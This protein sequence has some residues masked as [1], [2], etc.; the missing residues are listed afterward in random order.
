M[1]RPVHR[2]KKAKRSRSAVILSPNEY[3][4]GVDGGGT[5]THALLMDR[6]QQVIGEGTAGPS[7][8]L[9]VGVETAVSNILK[10]VNQACDNAVISRADIVS[11]T[12][13]L[14]G[15]RRSDMK[16]RVRASFQEQSRIKHIN[17][18]TDAE[19]AL[20]ATTL[21][22]PGVVVIAGTGSVCLGMS[23]EDKYAMSGGWGP[24]AGD[25]GGGA[26]IARE[27]LQAVAKASDGRGIPT[28][29]S[30]RAS[31][32]FRASGPENLIV[33]IYSPHVDNSRIAGFAEFVVEA[34]KRGDSVAIDIIAAA[35]AELG[36]AA[37]AVIEKLGLKRKKVPIGCVGSVFKA[38]ELLTKPMIDTIHTIAPKAFLT[39]PLMPPAQAAAVMA[40]GNG[41]FGT[42]G[43]V[44]IRQR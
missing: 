33:A 17:V 16:Q 39:E 25:E 19:I 3:F 27:A 28:I 1:N 15:V 23:G 14:A 12:L 35:G 43:K 22:K 13:G 44:Q 18:L 31:E 5:K 34:A 21:G 32:Y 9:R 2:L 20:F 37:C 6:K 26:G 7:N 41:N 40:L 38:G 4:L 29:L 42:N 11:G 24:L 30:K 36:L 8:P 10:A